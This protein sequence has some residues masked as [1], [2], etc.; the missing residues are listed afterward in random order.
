MPQIDNLYL[1]S[2]AVELFAAAIIG[3][4]LV[5]YRM[6]RRYQHRN[7]TNSLFLAIL[8]IQML[9][10]VSDAL[11]WVLLYDPTADKIPLVKILT[12]MTDFMTVT[13]TAVYAYL[14]THYITQRKNISFAFPRT[15]SAICGMV[16]ILWVLCLF[17]DWYIWYEKDGSQHEGPLYPV[18][19]ILGILLLI[20]CVLYTLW[21]RKALGRR[22]TWILS[23]YGIFPLVGDLIEPYWPVTPLLLAPTLSLVLMYVV[24]H[25]QQLH[26]AVE[27]DLQLAQLN[28]KL[29]KQ[30]AELS[31]S[32][33]H[34]MLSQIQPHF[35][36]NALSSIS[37]LC[38]K[39]PL[40]AQTALSDF[41]DYLRGNLDS[42][43]RAAP[44]PFS[45]ELKHV[46]TYLALEKMRFEEELQVVYDIEAEG[47]LLPALTVQPLVENA[48]K[49]GVGKK[50]G[51]GTVTIST[52]E[53][54][55]GYL[56]T[57]ADDGIGYD[58]AKSKN[59]GRTHIGIDNV[60]SRLAA[61]VGGHLTIESK[62]GE[63]T[64][65]IIQ[66]P[67]GEGHEYISCG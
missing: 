23:T 32:R 1:L 65:A 50:P 39:D 55:D 46:K 33:I 40:K 53:Q 22:D 51:G 34:I 45:K 38:E 37:V 12:L 47:F 19:W 29:S 9:L 27:Q 59:D 28:M 49:Y 44:V 67:K 52:R 41:S 60:R 15:V 62:V 4:L 36:F 54:E 25:T 24:L 2:A 61:M 57:V 17:N 58:P 20:S 6:E 3:I 48:V 42:L 64:L 18:I 11:I 30:E 13:L 10:L 5:G 14:I 56:I 43:R 16:L 31:E 63:G 66:I 35:L 7:K 21:H 26:R 8:I